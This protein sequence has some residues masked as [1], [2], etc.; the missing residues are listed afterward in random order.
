MITEK[1][2]Q[3]AGLIGS[4]I[5]MERGDSLS[6]DDGP[7][8]GL[9][10]SSITNTAIQME[11]EILREFSD[12]PE[13]N[14]ILPPGHCTLDN[15]LERVSGIMKFTCMSDVCK[16]YTIREEKQ[17]EA[18]RAMHRLS[19]G[20]MLTLAPMRTL[21]IT[22]GT[23]MAKGQIVEAPGQVLAP[24]GG[25]VSSVGET[26]AIAFDMFDAAPV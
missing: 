20:E 12:H 26:R 4:E 17:R 14:G 24:N 9:L 15:T 3:Y 21:F 8:P 6:V 7:P 18:H 1:R 10:I 5:R 19:D 2:M 11:G 25:V 22:K 13:H 23:M 16:F